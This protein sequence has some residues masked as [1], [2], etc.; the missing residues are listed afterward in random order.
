MGIL[1]TIVQV[2]AGSMLHIGQDLAPD[3]TVAAQPVGDDALWLV[4]QA[5]EKGLEK[6]L[7]G[8]G[9][10]SLL[11]KDVE[12]DPMLVHSAP[13]IEELAIH[14]VL[15]DLGWEAIAGAGGKFWGRPAILVWSGPF[16][17]ARAS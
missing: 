12:H 8:Y 7:G 4:L 13:E 1:S 14:A 6:S 11:H 17:P 9:I 5:G 10:P 15:D 16:V 2:A 3:H